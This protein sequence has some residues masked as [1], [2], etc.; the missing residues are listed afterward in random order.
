MEEERRIVHGYT[1]EELDALVRNTVGDGEPD[2]YA[3]LARLV[4]VSRIG[5][6][7][8]EMAMRRVCEIKDRTIT[9]LKPFDSEDTPKK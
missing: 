4:S 3:V 7:P 1:S 2:Y 8:I 9:G 5:S 6:L